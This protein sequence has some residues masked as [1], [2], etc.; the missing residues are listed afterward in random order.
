MRRLFERASGRS[1]LRPIIRRLRIRQKAVYSTLPVSDG[2]RK[3]LEDLKNELVEA[4][5]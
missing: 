4:D 5:L 1:W 3:I 2:E